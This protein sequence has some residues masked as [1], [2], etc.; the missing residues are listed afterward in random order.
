MFFDGWYGVIR[1]IVVGISA[2]SYLV[3]LLRISGKRTLA[4][5][6]A[7][8]FV[9]T[10]ALG[11]T[12][13]SVLVSSGVA[14]AEGVAALTLLAALQYAVAWMSVRHQGFR[15]LVRSEPR[16]LYRQGFLRSAMRRERVTEGDLREAARRQGQADLE[17]V[18]A[19]VLET[20]G[21]FSVLSS[22]R[23]ESSVRLPATGETD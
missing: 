4:K 12:L 14:L 1:V 15:R 2:Y 16:L 23:P 21:S 22:I 20:D 6:N 18:G 3:L 11:S 7:F 8:D 10:V 19:I 17:Q 13:S 5:L 9:V